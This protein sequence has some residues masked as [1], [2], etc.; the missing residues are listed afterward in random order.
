MATTPV[1]DHCLRLRPV[2][3]Q[4][5]RASPVARVPLCIAHIGASGTRVRC[6]NFFHFV[7]SP[8]ATPK[9]RVLKSDRAGSAGGA[10]PQ[11]GAAGASG[12]R[13]QVADGKPCALYGVAARSAGEAACPTMR[14]CV[15][16]GGHSFRAIPVLPRCSPVILLCGVFPVVDRPVLS[17][18][19][20]LFH[21]N[22]AGF[23]KFPRG[24]SSAR[25]GWH[26]E[27][28]LSRQNDQ[29]R[30]SLSSMGPTTTSWR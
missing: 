14:R 24:A 13:M 8:L 27:R 21:L 29:W 10:W 11:S 3:C 15:P 19:V 1:S 28:N 25:D 18:A 23:E 17:E 12:N 5:R 6:A 26:S 4:A 9:A 22:G 2:V 30:T 16:R 20:E 7:G